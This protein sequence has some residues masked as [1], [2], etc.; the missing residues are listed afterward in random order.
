MPYSPTE[1]PEWCRMP[2]KDHHSFGGCWLIALGD[3][4]AAGKRACEKCEHCEPEHGRLPGTK[5]S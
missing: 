2:E 4:R 5:D 3:I 1:I